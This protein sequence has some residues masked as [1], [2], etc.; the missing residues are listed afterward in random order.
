MKYIGITETGD[1]CFVPDWDLRLHEANIII[2]KELTDEMI[3]KLVQHKDRIIFHHTVTGL[4]GTAFEPNVKGWRHESDQ[5]IKLIKAG[6]PA[7]HYVLRVDPI[8]P[9]YEETFDDVKEVLNRW[10]WIRWHILETELDIHTTLRCRI[11]VLDGYEHVK[12]R[13]KNHGLPYTEDIKFTANQSMFKKVEKLLQPYEGK[14]IFE[15]CAEEGFDVYFIN[16][17]GCASLKDLEILGLDP[18][19]YIF[20]HDKQ[21]PTCRCLPK[22]QILGIKPG[23]CPHQCL[24]CFWKD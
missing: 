8:I 13:I 4:G 11:S 12:K 5:F 1:P 20:K 2:S 6:F 15:D 9:Y 14:F 22:K 23:R 16:P 21:R 7:D 10:N 24:Y 18:S 19:E 3:E 17:V